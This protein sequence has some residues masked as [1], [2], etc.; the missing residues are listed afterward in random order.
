[1]LIA[2]TTV[3]TRAEADALATGVIAA[4]LAA[5]VQIEG[6]ITA[7]Y[8]WQGKPE[9]AQEFRL[10]FKLLPSHSLL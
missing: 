10:A 9:Q 6:P 1:M 8:R 4:N 2:W 3:A 5:C 7:H